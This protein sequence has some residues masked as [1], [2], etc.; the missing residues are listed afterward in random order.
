LHSYKFTG[1][2]HSNPGGDD[3]VHTTPSEVLD[4]SPWEGQDWALIRVLPGPSMRNIV[5]DPDQHQPVPV[6]GHLRSDQLFQGNVW[7]CAGMSGV[8]TGFLNATEGSVMIGSSVFSVR[9]IMLDKE[10]GL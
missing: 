6:E 2:L 7:V 9:T 8:T 10:L 5:V 4:E 1:T 3:S